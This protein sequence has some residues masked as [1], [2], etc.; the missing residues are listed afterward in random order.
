MGVLKNFLDRTSHLQKDP[1]IKEKGKKN[2]KNEVDVK[3][4]FST[5]L[6]SPSFS[7]AGTFD[8]FN[9]FN[10]SFFFIKKL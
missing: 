6:F 9:L 3:N 2:K 5:K 8:A 1:P 7:R 4:C 10:F